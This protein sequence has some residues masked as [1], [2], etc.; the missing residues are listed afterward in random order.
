VKW[1]DMNRLSGA[2]GAWSR[3]R[4]RGIGAGVVECD[5]R[6]TPGAKAKS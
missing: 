3:V 4:R 2:S 6:F 5:E 1:A